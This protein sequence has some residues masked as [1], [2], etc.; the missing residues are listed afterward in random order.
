MAGFSHVRASMRKTLATSQLTHRLNQFI[1]CLAILSATLYIAENTL[2]FRA[3]RSASSN[4]GQPHNIC[5]LHQIDNNSG[6]TDS[7]EIVYVKSLHRIFDICEL[8]VVIVNIIDF[9]L[10]FLV[11]DHKVAFLCSITSVVD[12]CSIVVLFFTWNQSAIDAKCIEILQFPRKLFPSH[13]LA[14][15]YVAYVMRLLRTL[16]LLRLVKLQRLLESLDSE[17]QQKLLD[18]CLGVLV[19][20]IFVGGWL[21]IIER[22]KQ[23]DSC[24]W[25]YDYILCSGIYL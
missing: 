1:S 16:R 21:Q 20:W 2:F 23:E 7:D 5:T 10:F 11:S 22:W 4:Y 3:T 12:L 13:T 14:G 19:T 25:Y 8:T 17:L 9:L 18:I 6:W 24:K 15:L